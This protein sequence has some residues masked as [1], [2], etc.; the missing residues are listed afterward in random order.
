[1]ANGSAEIL[2][3]TS[4][5]NAMTCLV[6]DEYKYSV[7]SIVYSIV[8]AVGFIS[9][10]LALYI[11]CWVTRNKNASTVYLINLAV[12]DLLFALSLPLRVTYY[13]NGLHWPFGDVMCR[14]SSYIFYLSMYCSIFFLTCLSVSRYLSIAQYFK[15]QRLFTFRRCTLT[16]ACIWLFVSVTSSPFLL[17]GTHVIDGKVKCFQP[18]TM[19]N[20]IRI[21]NLNYLA[22]VIGFLLP[23]ATI[24]VCY[25]LMIKHIMRTSWS[26]KKVRR[27]VATIVLVLGVFLICFL[28][29]HIQRTVHLHFLVHHHTNCDLENTL[30]KSVV[31]TLCLAT[32]NSCFDPLLYIF[33]GQGF[34]KFVRTR[35]M[36]INPNMVSSSS[37]TKINTSELYSPQARDLELCPMGP[38]DVAQTPAYGGRVGDDEEQC[39][40]EN[41][42]SNR[43]DISQ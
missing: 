29:Y 36:K 15:L 17:S 42:F 1:M 2:M 35:F 16:C 18:I 41:L 33:V 3:N 9:N 43:Q 40:R 31:A 21:A 28:P 22:L 20:W 25:T 12:A 8:F 24:L 34:K 39:Q 7:Y 11:F 19:S 5:I 6:S 13:L 27:D 4:T 14:L 32:A 10:L 26:R 30:R 38:S 23:F 37:S